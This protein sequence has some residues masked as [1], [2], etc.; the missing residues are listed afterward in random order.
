MFKLSSN[1]LIWTSQRKAHWY[2]RFSSVSCSCVSN[3]LWPNGLQH[4]RLPCPLPTPRVYP[5]ACP[6]SRWCHPTISSS[7]I[8][9]SSRL[10]SSP[11]SGSFQMSQFSASGG[12]NIGVSASAS[13]LPMNIQDW[14]IDWLDLLA[15]QGTLKSL[16]QHHSSEASIL[17]HSAFF[18]V[19]FLVAQ[20]VKHLPIMWETQLLSLGQE[21]LLE[22]EIHSSILPGKS[23]GWRGLVG[24]SP[25]GCKELDTTEWLHSLTHSLTHSFLYSPTLTS[26][27]D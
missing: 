25:Q 5:N 22:K 10:Q 11:A 21:D 4:A 27:H 13:V 12:Q 8:P 19:T 6:L 1:T 14:S 9:F 17:W 23:H 15:V 26:I 16:L 20:M 18:L 2:N 7:V 24:Y 3:S